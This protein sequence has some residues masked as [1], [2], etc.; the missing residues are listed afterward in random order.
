MSFYIIGKLIKSSLN[1][2]GEV[3]TINPSEFSNFNILDPLPTII[4][5]L[6]TLGNYVIM[7][8]QPPTKIIA[9]E[10]NTKE[11]ILSPDG[12]WKDIYIFSYK[13]LRAPNN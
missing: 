9:V 4:I 10:G 5:T 8:S 11:E 12:K 6:K 1:I 2:E 7:F 3:I 13:I